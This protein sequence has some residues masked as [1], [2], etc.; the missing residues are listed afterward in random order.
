MQL[1]VHLGVPL[2]TTRYKVNGKTKDVFYWAAQLPAG[3]KPRADKDE[4]DDIQWV[5]IK[6]ARTMLTNPSDL[7]PLEAFENLWATSGLDTHPIIIARHT[8]AKPRANWSAAE[9]E[10]PLAGTGK[11]QALALARLLTAWEPSRVLS[12]PWLR[13]VQ[14]VAPYVNEYSL[15]VKEKKSLSEAGAERHPKRTVKTIAS[16]FEKGTPALVC[17]HRPVLPVVLDAVAE[18]LLTKKQKEHLPAK[19]PYLEPGDILVL[20]VSAYERGGIVSAEVVRP[21]TD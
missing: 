21:F 9:D 19:D 6:K 15:T 13:C 2:G 1:R 4:V 11:R 18:H 3:Q 14:T 10:R 20:Q 8:K 12:S 17:T 5:S 7:Q 16:L